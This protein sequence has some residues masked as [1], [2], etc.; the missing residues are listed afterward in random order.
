MEASRPTTRPAA[1]MTTHFFSTSAGFAEYVRMDCPSFPR[2]S[3]AHTHAPVP[4]EVRRNTPACPARSTSTFWSSSTKSYSY[5]NGTF[6]PLGGIRPLPENGSQLVFGPL[7]RAA[8]R[9]GKAAA[10][11]VHVERQHGKSR[12]IGVG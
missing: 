5:K 4:Q 3:A 6:I 12:A 2:P 8:A 1:S 9:T 7:K 10:S 11:P